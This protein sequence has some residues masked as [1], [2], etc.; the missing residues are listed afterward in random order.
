MEQELIEML[1]EF[2]EE[3]PALVGGALEKCVELFGRDEWNR[4]WEG[5]KVNA[6]WCWINGWKTRDGGS[7]TIT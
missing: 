3:S 7:K 6:V 2:K 4:M 1:E 5:H